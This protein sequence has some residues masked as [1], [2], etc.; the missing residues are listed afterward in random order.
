MTE[1]RR[2]RLVVG[3][4]DHGRR[5]DAVLAAADGMES[6]AEAQRLI[7]AGSVTVNGEARPKRHALATGDVVEAVLPPDR[8]A[9]ELKAEDLGV[10]VV[11]ADDRLLVVDKP[12]GMVTHPSRGHSSGTL[13]HGL[14]GAGA[15]GG[16]DPERPGI[17]HRLDR[18]TSG[19]LL[20]ARD[21][22]TH[23]RLSRMMRDREIGRRYL[24]LV[25]G[26][27]PPALTVD[28]PL[29]R[30]PRRRTRQA[31]LAHGG[32]DA[33]THFRRLEQIGAVALVEARLETG[34][35]HQVRVHLESAG[36]PVFGDPV[37]GRG[38]ADHGLGRQFL[39]A[40]ALEFD[41]PE[42]GEH[43]AFDSPLPPDLETALAGARARAAGD[44]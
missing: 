7:E 40:Y 17:V 11:Y 6:R 14:L 22:R 32:R 16:D 43:L 12:A 19:L 31:V 18:D 27:F 28:R 29:G 4:D 21:E 26:D 41:H 33:V 35:T 9:Q 44:G 25:Y 2:L 30:D 39:H 8:G 42:T 34:R 3:A 20:V 5:L 24:A 15:G 23:R 36:H 1:A 37:Y 38:R 10:P 13:V